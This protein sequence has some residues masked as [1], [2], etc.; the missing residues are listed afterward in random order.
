MKQLILFIA[1]IFL[2]GCKSYMPIQN[3]VYSE[4]HQTTISFD[5]D[6]V[7]FEAPYYSCPIKL[8]VSQIHRTGKN[9][10]EYLACNG[11]KV[12]IEDS[13]VFVY[14]P[15]KKF[16]KQYKLSRTYKNVQFQ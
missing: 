3:I 2:I 12:Q 15:S 6:E 8:H 13:N 4:G 10:T 7:K 9:R 1:T 5:Y 14:A 11:W 16:F